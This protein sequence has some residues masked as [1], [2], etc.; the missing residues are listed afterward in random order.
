M[1]MNPYSTRY[2]LIHVIYTN[3]IFEK[4]ETLFI[5]KLYI[6]LFKTR[7]DHWRISWCE[8]YLLDGVTDLGDRNL[9]WISRWRQ[10]LLRSRRV[11]VTQQISKVHVRTI[12]FLDCQLPVE[13]I[14]VGFTVF[15]KYCKN[16]DILL[17][18]HYL[19]HI[20]IDLFIFLIITIYFVILITTKELLIIIFSWSINLIG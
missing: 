9:Q 20:S 8:R 1:Y 14:S 7:I 6:A 15:R 3:Y 11:P 18:F 4:S 17:L 2:V 10:H 19:R 5:T 16:D 13:C 12:S